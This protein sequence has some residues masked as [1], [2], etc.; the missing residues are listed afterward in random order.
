MRW[1]ELLAA[2]IGLSACMED[3]AAAPPPALIALQAAC[4]GGDTQAC[5]QVLEYQQRQQALRQQAAASVPPF[6]PYYLPNVRAY[7]PVLSTPRQT[8]CTSNFG[9]MNC[10][11]Y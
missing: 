3:E 7:S 8:T 6:Q 2:T 10:T 11:S 9:V 5:A 1:M 4:D